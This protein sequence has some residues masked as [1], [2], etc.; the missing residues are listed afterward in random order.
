MW[1]PKKLKNPDQQFCKLSPQINNFYANSVW[2]ENGH[3]M[4]LGEAVWSDCWSKMNCKASPI[5]LDGFRGDPG[6]PKTPK[7]STT[8][9]NNFHTQIKATILNKQKNS[10][11]LNK[12]LRSSETLGRWWTS[13]GRPFVRSTD[14]L[15]FLWGCRP[16]DT[17]RPGG[18]PHRSA[19][20]TPP[21][22]LL[23]RRQERE[24]KQAEPKN[25]GRFSASPV[26]RPGSNPSRIDRA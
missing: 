22:E 7:I 9:G 13:V 18:L 1:R 14:H 4:G 11:F 25:I 20:Q 21:V 15:G 10:T 19:P 16:P 24:T 5:D 8:L 3:K 2:T 23:G 12:V 17:P 6:H 26:S